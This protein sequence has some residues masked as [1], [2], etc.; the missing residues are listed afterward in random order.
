MAQT[1]S[2]LMSFEHSRKLLSDYGLPLVHTVCTDDP[3]EVR[4]QFSKMD[5]PVV[6]KATGP[7]ISHK[8]E[9]GL[10]FLSITC[11]EQLDDSIRQIKEA[12]ANDTGVKFLV[13]EQLRGAEL[14]IGGK[15]DPSF[16][17]VLL[18]GT[19]GIYAQLL[20]D[21][22]VRPA[23]VSSKDAL[24]MI[25]QTNAHKFV[26]GFR[27]M[28]MN[29]PEIVSLLKK[30]SR[31]LVNEPSIA[32]FDFNPVIATQTSAKIVDARIILR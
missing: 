10:V 30:A 8:T 27:G 5:K 32:E 17:P 1:M 14:I 11:R 21:V 18:F 23:P 4:W 26:E 22:S 3:N 19:G 7:N 29:K 24:E 2:S 6:L 28:H 13:Q 9:K 25:G 31:M 16:G 15:R 20:D 12:T